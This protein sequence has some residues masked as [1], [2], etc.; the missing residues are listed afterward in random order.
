[1]L[2]YPPDLD[3]YVQQKIASGQFQSREEFAA[4]AIRMYREFEARRLRMKADIAASLEQADRGQCEPLDMDAIKQQ[5]CEQVSPTG[6]S[7]A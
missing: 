6:E 1:M 2:N 7:M 3:A 5:L 4:E